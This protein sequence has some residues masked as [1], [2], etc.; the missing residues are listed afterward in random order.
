MYNPI[1]LIQRI[2]ALGDVV[3]GSREFTSNLFRRALCDLIRAIPTEWQSEAR[4]LCLSE[5]CPVGIEL[6]EKLER[7]IESHTEDIEYSLVFY[8]LIRVAIAIRGSE[9]RYTG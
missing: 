7:D 2:N 4:D 9:L 1:K 5:S 3:A 8:P 6:A